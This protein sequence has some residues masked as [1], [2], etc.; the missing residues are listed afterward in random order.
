MGDLGSNIRA[1]EQEEDPVQAKSVEVA[2][3]WGISQLEIAAKRKWRWASDREFSFWDSCKIKIVQSTFTIIFI[4]CWCCFGNF[5]YWISN[6]GCPSTRS[7]SVPLRPREF[8]VRVP[9]NLVYFPTLVRSTV[10]FI[11]TSLLTSSKN[12]FCNSALFIFKII[13]VHSKY[14]KNK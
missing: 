13:Q 10:W 4:P 11:L 14:L 3:V 1:V 7:Y 9:L 6:N 5:T 2:N 12:N 8:L